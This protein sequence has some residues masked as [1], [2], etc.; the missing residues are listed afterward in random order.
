MQGLP[1]DDERIYHTHNRQTTCSQIAVFTHS[2][3]AHLAS[4]PITNSNDRMPKMVAA[5]TV[6][7]VVECMRAGISYLYAVEVW[8]AKKN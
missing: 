1:N 5:A 7:T 4:A 6:P 3:E 2:L 8:D